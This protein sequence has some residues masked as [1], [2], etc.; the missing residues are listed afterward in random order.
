M[1]SV[2]RRAGLSP[3]PAI[4]AH[5]ARARVLK[6]GGRRP[7]LLERVGGVFRNFLGSATTTG[8]VFVHHPHGLSKE[9]W[10]GGSKDV[11]FLNVQKQISGIIAG[12]LSQGGKDLLMIGTANELLAYDVQRNSDLFHKEMPD[13][14][15]SLTLGSIGA[16]SNEPLVFAGGNCS[17]QGFNGEGNDQF[18]TVTGDNVC[19]MALCDLIG[20]GDAQLLVGSE[21]FDLRV[22]QESGEML[23]EFSETEAVT[24]LCNLGGRRFGYALENGSVGTYDGPQRSWRSKMKAAPITIC[25]FDMT[26]DGVPELVTA[27]ADGTVDVRPDDPGRGGEVILK[28][29][30]ATC[31][32]GL[33]QADYRMDG[34]QTLLVVSTEGEA[35][36]YLPIGV[37]MKLDEDDTPAMAV[38]PPKK[39]DKKSRRNKKASAAAAA[40]GQDAGGAPSGSFG[41]PHHDIA[42]AEAD[43]EAQRRK[44]LLRQQDLT[45]ELKNYDSA[46]YK[47]NADTFGAMDPKLF[48]K[49]LAC[50]CFLGREVRREMQ[51]GSGS[52]PHVN[53]T[54]SLDKTVEDVASIK[55]MI[56]FAEGIFD[57]DSLVVHPRSADVSSSISV[58]L[59]I[60]ANQKIDISVRIMVCPRGG[61]N[62]LVVKEMM[63]EIPQF[64]LFDKVPPPPVETSSSVTLPIHAISTAPRIMQWVSRNFLVGEVEQPSFHLMALRTMQHVSFYLQKEELIIQ[65]Q[66]M[67]LAAELV[68]SLLQYL[69][70]REM[71]AT[72]DFPGEINELQKTLTTVNEIQGSRIQLSADLA[73]RSTLAKSLLFRA[74]DARLLN[75]MDLMTD[76]YSELNS[77]NR[78]LIMAYTTRCTQHVELLNCLKQV[79]QH[80]QRAA[81]MRGEPPPP[82]HM[83]SSWP[84]RRLPFAVCA[85]VQP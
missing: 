59:D 29:S 2:A 25:G 28:D 48:Q 36:G 65:T 45:R 75:E 21:D 7:D 6:A 73:E 35:R 68:Q 4:A 55:C 50:K 13:G 43:H 83:P 46:K 8:K 57:G 49:I 38:P 70:I 69:N 39:K 74:E 53:L 19:S 54:V 26:M 81:R 58:S 62:Q 51:R 1:V 61:G 11:S 78:D 9:D 40:A 63:V 71:N 20:D 80:I 47:E 23:H 30:F 72:V 17:I 15:L 34:T 76:A 16:S 10:T 12:P 14:V 41:Q 56:L 44:L 27:W 22:F 31:L 33:A 66:D 79:N 67:N 32:A 3:V 52:V 18:W 84:L 24:A 77:L 64:A 82:R 85:R 42:S 5:R 37:K 60:P